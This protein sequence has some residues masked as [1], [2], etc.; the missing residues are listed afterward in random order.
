MCVCGSQYLLSLKWNI[1][2]ISFRFAFFMAWPTGSLLVSF[3]IVVVVRSCCSC[4]CCC[5]CL[6]RWLLATLLFS[7]IWPLT[8]D[9]P[10][11]TRGEC[12]AL[13]S[14]LFIYFGLMQ[15]DSTRLCPAA[16]SVPCSCHVVACRQPLSPPSP[17]SLLT[18]SSYCNCSMSCLL[19]DSGKLYW[20]IGKLVY[21]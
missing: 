2:I 8:I 17:S 6:V 10:K 1:F 18:G 20:V 21:V 7:A 11:Q 15:A 4:C 9:Q 5:W 12:S 13:F 19:R 16:C 3:L 14:G